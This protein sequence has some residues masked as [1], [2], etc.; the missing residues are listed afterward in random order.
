MKILPDL[1][2]KIGE[3]GDKSTGQLISA[4]CLMNNSGIRF[5]ELFDIRKR[6]FDIE[7]NI[8]RVRSRKSKNHNQTTII[9]SDIFYFKTVIAKLNP[10]DKIIRLRPT[11]LAI[12]LKRYMKEFNIPNLH[13]LRA[14]CIHSLIEIGADEPQISFKMRRNYNKEDRDKIDWRKV[15]DSLITLESLL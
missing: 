4:L 14:D 10:D 2:K 15:K 9:N 3:S 7:S 6:D 5:S 11:I 13:F 8:L 12:K 1:I